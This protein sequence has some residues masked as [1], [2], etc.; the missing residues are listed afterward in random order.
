MN[1][2]HE[3][4]NIF[5]KTKMCLK[6]RKCKTHLHLSTKNKVRLQYP[7]T[8]TNKKNLKQLKNLD[9]YG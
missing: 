8:P 9:K 7:K 4:K 2:E 3:L 5:L 1:Y 6:C